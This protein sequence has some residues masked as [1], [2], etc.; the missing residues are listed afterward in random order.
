MLRVL[1]A[2]EWILGAGVRGQA[3]CIKCGATVLRLLAGEE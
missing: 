3:F 2:T 1:H